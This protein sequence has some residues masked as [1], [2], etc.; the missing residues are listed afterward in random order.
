MSH[1][2]NSMTTLTVKEA[3]AQMDKWSLQCPR[4]NKFTHKKEA[5]VL[6][7]DEAVCVQ[8]GTPKQP[9][10]T[11]FGL[12]R[13]SQKD[14]KFVNVEAGEGTE[15][16]YAAQ[17]DSAFQRAKPGGK[18][19]A[20]L[21][22]HEWD[23]PGTQGNLVHEFITRLVDRVIHGLA[24]GVPDPS[25]LDADGKPILVQ[26]VDVP[27]SA[28]TA[29]EREK[30]FRFSLASPIRA[31]EGTYAPSLKT[32]VRYSVKSFPTGEIV[33][34]DMD[35]LDASRPETTRNTPVAIKDQL[36]LFKARSRGVFVIKVNPLTFKRNEINMTID[37][38]K[39]MI[40]PSQSLFKNVQFRLDA[41][42]DAAMEDAE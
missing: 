3:L 21:T 17:A 38:I 30:L 26:V 7:G 24:H 31:S 12:S 6:F 28:N 8:I 37:I 11:Q 10:Y 1:A 40:M 34:L 25:Q 20:Q 14:G 4:V 16:A 23:T 15:W 5:P 42:D 35:L 33:G 22:L 39:A 2:N 18:L 19:Q 29:E 36:A 41:D 27:A 32:K 9:I 13:W